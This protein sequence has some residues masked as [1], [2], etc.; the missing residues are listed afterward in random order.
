M[1]KAKLSILATAVV[2][3]LTA[4]GG[5][6]SSSV[7]REE[8]TNNA[9]VANAGAAQSVT[10]GAEV[11][12]SGAESSDADNDTLTYA[13]EL[14]TV[15]DGS[16]A[17]LSSGTTETVTFTPDIGGEYVVSLIVNDGTTNSSASTVTITANGAPTANAGVDQNVFTTTPVTLNGSDSSDPDGDSLTYSWTLS[18]QPSGSNISLSSDTAVRPSFTPEVDGTYTFSLTVSDGT[19]TSSADVVEITAATENSAPVADAGVDREVPIE[20]P[21]VLDGSGSGDTD[22]DDI[23]FAWT[24][25]SAP[26]GSGATLSDADTVSPAFTPDLEGDYEFSL[27]VNDGTVDSAADS[28]TISAVIDNAAPQADA[29]ADQYVAVGAT[30]QLEN[31]STDADADLLT[32]QWAF[33]SVPDGSAAALSDP[34]AETP[35]FV[36]DIEGTYVVSLVV[37]DGTEDS[38]ADNVSIDAVQP[39]ILLFRKSGSTDNYYTFPVGGTTGGN[40]ERVVTE[41]PLPA[42]VAVQTFRLQA[43]GSDFTVTALSAVDQLGVV[44]PFFDGLE[45]GVIAAGEEVTFSLSSPLTGGE[46]ASLVFTFTIEETGQTFTANYAFSTTTP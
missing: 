8:P 23:T 14:T 22:G 46:V 15:P 43:V 13:W 7:E 34:T 37:N 31:N 18:S 41:D 45:E 11:T 20:S 9:P 2:L 32:S 5:G 30:V 26:Q 28:V 27:V 1:G 44:T 17:E 36:A 3:G 21:L 42:S 4:C 10:T 6:S 29:G 12:V 16:T 39:Q 35:S 40:I 25:V 33:V 38:T 24:L 19:A